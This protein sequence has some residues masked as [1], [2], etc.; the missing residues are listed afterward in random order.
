[1]SQPLPTC[2]AAAAAQPQRNTRPNWND[3]W[4]V[5]AFWPLERWLTPRLAVDGHAPVGPDKR[6]KRVGEMKTK[7]KAQAVRDIQENA[8]SSRQHA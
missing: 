8:A 7:T 2:T 6:Q 4:R 3:G 1:M 5:P